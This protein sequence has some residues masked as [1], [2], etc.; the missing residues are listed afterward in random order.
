MLSLKKRV[1]VNM[2]KT[3]LIVAG[4]MGTGASAAVDIVKEFKGSYNF[5]TEIR[6]IKD[7]YGLHELEQT[8][9]STNWDVIRSS[10]AVWDFI[11]ASKIWS[12]FGGNP[13]SAPGLSYKKRI[14]KD[15]MRYTYEFVTEICDCEFRCDFYSDAFR[16]N[17]L[18]YVI[19]RNRRYIEKITKGKLRIANRKT[20]QDY[21]CK[22][23]EERFLSA[24]KKY[25]MQIFTPVNTVDDVRIII[26]DQAI[27]GNNPLLVTRYFENGK[28]II[29]DRDPRD[30]Y[31]DN[32]EYPDF[33]VKNPNS[34]QEAK[35][36][37]Q[38]FLASREENKQ[39]HPNILYL[40]FE[41]LVS[42]YE[43]ELVKI[44][45]FLNLSAEDHLRKGEF[46]NPMES[47]KNMQIWKKHYKKF[48]IAI[49]YISH[50]LSNYLYDE[51]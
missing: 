3:Y 34:I 26:L 24:L 16:K 36:F 46:F 1:I 49:D 2:S 5:E 32:M 7:P 14:N 28:I 13:L 9:L 11:D 39:N 27:S 15:Y 23:S 25:L 21:L 38:F 48:N 30:I 42:N 12:R 33:L 40:Q 44:R 47:R 29:V 10:T 43:D 51:K 18:Q 35:K 19:D 45:S 17:Y 37:C 4:Y 41:N 31:V 8:V 20:R 50:N 6:M 22:P